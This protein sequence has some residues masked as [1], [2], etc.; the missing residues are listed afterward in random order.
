[1]GVVLGPCLGG[2]YAPYTGRFF[3]VLVV[4][5]ALLVVIILGYSF[6]WSWTGLHGRTLYDWLQLLIIP[7]VLAVGGY[8]FNYTT[9]RA[10]Q[11]NT[12]LRDQTEQE[13]ASDNQRETAL[14]AYIDH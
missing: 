11:R 1:M 13:I 8:L 14:Q 6:N 10:E 12:Q 9:T 3:T 7:A 4:L 2:R 5:L